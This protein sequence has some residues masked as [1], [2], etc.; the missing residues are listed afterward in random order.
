MKTQNV[1]VTPLWKIKKDQYNGV[2]K[3]QVIVSATK[4]KQIRTSSFKVHI[5]DTLPTC[6]YE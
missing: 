3:L 4:V 2:P 6:M 5:G 1:W